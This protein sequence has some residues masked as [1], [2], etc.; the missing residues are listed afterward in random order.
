MWDTTV[1]QLAALFR[2]EG[3]SIFAVTNDAHKLQLMRK[4]GELRSRP[5]YRCSLYISV[6]NVK[7][8]QLINYGLY[9]KY[10][11]YKM[12]RI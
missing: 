3:R 1:K 6:A 10:Y 4:L 2:A 11:V 9:E 12:W 8:N 7:N 5:K